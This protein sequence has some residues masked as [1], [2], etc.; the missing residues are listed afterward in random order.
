[1]LTS[2]GGT[3]IGGYAIQGAGAMLIK[4]IEG[5]YDNV[6]GLPLRSTLKIIEQV[7]SR[8]DEL[9][10]DEEEGAAEEEE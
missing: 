2:R 6:V 4:K 7:M 3:V 10:E 8:D 1:M 5:S 9:G